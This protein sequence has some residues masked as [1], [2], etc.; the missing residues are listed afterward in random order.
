MA[1]AGAGSPAESFNS[2]STELEAPAAPAGLVMGMPV[3]MQN[4]G[5]HKS[6]P[7][8]SDAACNAA[9]G[10]VTKHFKAAAAKIYNQQSGSSALILIL[11]ISLN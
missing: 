7:A 5:P 9:I 11:I 4:G 6:P 3:H 1:H 8:G 10:F 2:G